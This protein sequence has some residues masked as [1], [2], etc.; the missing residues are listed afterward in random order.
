MNPKDTKNQILLIANSSWYLSHYR[1]LLLNKLKSKQNY[2]LITISP[3]DSYTSEISKISM[4]ISWKI[5]RSRNKNI[6]LLFI[7]LL[8]LILIFKRLKPRLVHSHTLKTNFLTSITS[9]IFGIPCVISFAGLGQIANAKGIKRIIFLLIIKIMIFLSFRQLSKNII[10]KNIKRTSFIFQNKNDMIFVKSITNIP[11]KNSFLIFGSGVPDFYL[12]RNKSNY[13]MSDKHIKSN[14][15]EINFHLIYLS[16]LLKS[17]GI[18]TFI[19]IALFYKKHRSS[20]YG[21]IDSSSNDSISNKYINNIKGKNKNIKFHGQIKN[22]LLNQNYRYPIL[23]VP[24]NYGEGLPRGIIEALALK[25]PV[26]SSKKASCNIFDESLIYIAKDNSINSYKICINKIID[27]FNNG[28]IKT[29]LNRGHKFVKE[30]LL[31]SNIV[32]KTISIYK[33]M[34][35]T[36]YKC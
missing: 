7:S 35:D 1:K 15:K 4:N 8:R 2:T 25:I 31:E 29:K 6:F 9:F 5:T 26:I 16:R 32:N 34:E 18:I 11:N 12:N 10:T 28:F 27:D 23:L 20:V 17:K 3:T 24:S 19:E 22:P 21:L 36:N 33:Y 13:W 30:K 14:G